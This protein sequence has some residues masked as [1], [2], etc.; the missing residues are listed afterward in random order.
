[1]Q[2]LEIFFGVIGQLLSFNLSNIEKHEWEIFQGYGFFSLVVFLVVVL[3]AYWFHLYRSEKK[4]ERN[5]E[6]YADLALNDE[7]GDRI[8]EN[9]RS[10]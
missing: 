6:K 10:A 1:M 4:G 5:Y 2:D 3:Y 8:L 9:K 7:L